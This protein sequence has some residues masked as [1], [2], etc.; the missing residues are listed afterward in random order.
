MLSVGAGCIH[1]TTHTRTLF[2]VY[3][4][5]STCF[6]S[7]QLATDGGTELD[8]DGDRGA[9]EVHGLSRLRWH[10]D[11]SCGDLSHCNWHLHLLYRLLRMLQSLQEE[12]LSHGPGMTIP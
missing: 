1:H 10:A 2:D 3:I 5:L 4:L 9:D 11:K 6:L 8:N 7:F 12:L